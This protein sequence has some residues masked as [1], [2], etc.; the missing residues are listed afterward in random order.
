MSKAVS[1]DLIVTAPLVYFLLI[2]KTTIP[3]LSVIPVFLLSLWIG[4]RILPAEGKS[5]FNLIYTHHFQVAEILFIGTEAMLVYG[6]RKNYLRIRRSYEH[7]Q[8]DIREACL[9]YLNNRLFSQVLASE[10]SIFYYL[11][12]S[13]PAT[14]S[15]LSFSYHRNNGLKAITI[16]LITVILLETVGLHWLV[17]TWSNTWAWVLSCSSLYVL[18]LVTAQYKASVGLPIRISEAGLTI[19]NGLQSRV[20]VPF[21]Q[22]EQVRATFSDKGMEQEKVLR[23]N[24]LGKMGSHNVVIQ[25]KNTLEAQGMYGIRKPFRIIALDLDDPRSFV[26]ALNM[27][28]P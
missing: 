2:R 27:Y 17:A 12:V 18:L 23:V 9:Q 19:R 8:D 15:G 11:F 13:K 1:F 5:L 24:A 22:I 4:S 26:E 20:T 16:A 28:L 25:V 21:D 6:I 10:I 7:F 14:E 3:P